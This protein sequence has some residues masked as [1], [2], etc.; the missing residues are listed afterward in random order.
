MVG[1][2]SATL[3][4]DR[5]MEGL[6]ASESG[7]FHGFTYSGHPVSAAVALENIRILEEEGIIDQVANDTG[8][9]L[10]TKLQTL[11]DHPLVGDVRGRGMIAAVEF[12]ADKA[13]RQTFEP[14]G[15]VGKL[16]FQHGLNNGLISRP[17]NDTMAFSPPLSISRS[18]IDEM[19]AVFGQ[20]LDLTQQSLNTL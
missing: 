18:Q 10:Q 1:S 17:I 14:F 11:A 8:D 9:Y 12:V 19:V 7:F 3:V 20:C 6:Q 16:C 2:S 5:V 15:S 13:T 4:S